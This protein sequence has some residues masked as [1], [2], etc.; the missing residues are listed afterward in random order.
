VERR[1]RAAATD[2]EHVGGRSLLLEG[3]AQ[4]AEK[5]RIFY[6]DDGLIGGGLQY[7]DL[8]IRE[9]TRRDARRDG[10]ASRRCTACTREASG[11]I[12]C[13]EMPFL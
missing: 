4:L 5:A 11:L 8:F 12:S 1:V 7:V 6:G 13:G 3:F 9:R 2:L 10:I